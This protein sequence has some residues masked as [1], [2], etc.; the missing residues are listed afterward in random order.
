MSFKQFIPFT[1]PIGSGTNVLARGRI[2]R[3]KSLCYLIY[4]YELRY[5]YRYIRCHIEPNV[6]NLQA[7]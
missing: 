5:N 4:I 1:V 7:C 3:L 2:H 6:L